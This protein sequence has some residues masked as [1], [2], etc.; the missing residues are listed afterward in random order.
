M[1][2]I[3]KVSGAGGSSGGGGSPTLTPDTLLSKDIVEFTL[4]LC[5][6]PIAGLING[7]RSFYLDQTPLV[8]GS[9]ENNF[10]PFELHMYH[11]EVDASPVRNILGGT[12]SNS[13]IGVSLAQDIPV[14]RTTTGT[15]REQ[16]DQL[17]IRINFNTLL[18]STAA[19]DQLEDVAE[20]EIKYR[21]AGTFAWLDFF[22]SEA[23][24]NL[25]LNSYV[26]P[27]PPTP[28]EGP[29]SVSGSISEADASIG[30]GGGEPVADSNG[31][32]VA[33]IIDGTPVE[34]DIPL[35]G[36][37]ETQE[38]FDTT[39]FYI[40]GAVADVSL[41]GYDFSKTGSYGTLFINSTN[42]NYRYVPNEAVITALT[43]AATETFQFRS[44]LGRYRGDLTVS[45]Q[46]PAVIAITG[47][48]SSGYTKDFVKGVP[49]ID[50]DWE[51][52]VVKRSPD[53]EEY[54]TI[55]MTWESL[56]MVTTEDRSYD[57]LAVVRGLGQASDQFSGIPTFAGVYGCKTI[58]V[59]SNYDPITRYCT[60]A[61]DGT[62]KIAHTDNPAW[63]FYD[64]LTNELYGLKRYYPHLVVDRYSI[65]DAAKWCDELVPRPGGGFQPRFTYNDKIAQS[66]NAL[67]LAYQIAAI[68]GA[69]PSS[70]MNGT[71]SLKL[72]KPGLPQQIFGPESVSVDGFQYSFSDVT[73]RPNDVLVK[74]IN[75]NLEFGEDVRQVYDQDLI[76]RNGRIPDEIVVLGCNDV[77]EAQRR[78]YRRIL[79]ANTETTSVSFQTARAGLGLEPFDLIGIADPTMNWGVSGRVK[80]RETDVI[81]LRDTLFL[82]VDTDLTFTLQ[83]ASGLH[84]MTVVTTDPATKVLRI[85]AGTWPADAPEFAQFAVTHAQIGLV[86]P[87]RVMRIEEDPENPEILTFTA[88]EQNVNKYSDA[89]NMASTGTVDYSAKQ[90]TR[91]LQPV[92]TRLESGTNHLYIN[93]D[94]KVSSR[95]F[96]QWV[97]PANSY[98]DDF[99]VFYRRK[100]VEQQFTKKAVSG[101]EA[102][103]ENVVDGEKYFIY[104][105]AV[106]SVGKRS[107][108][109]IRTSHTVVG[110]TQ[111]PANVESLTATQTGPDVRLT[112]PLLDELDISHYEFRLGDENSS[113][114]TAELIG[115]SSTGSFLDRN[116]KISPAK[117][118]VKAYDTSQNTSL[119]STSTT[120]AVPAPGKPTASFSFDKSQFV[121]NIASDPTDEVGVAEYIVT[122][123][124]NEVFR[125]NTSRFSGPA[126]W[127]GAREY[128]VTVKNHAGQVSAPRVITGTIV[129]PAAPE[130]TTFVAETAYYLNWST[131]ASTLPIDYYIVKNITTD[132]TLVSRSPGNIYTGNVG[133]LG[134]YNFSVQAVDTAGNRGALGTG[135]VNIVAP[136]VASLNSEVS[137]SV[138]KLTWVGEAL[139]LPIR[140]YL[141]SEGTSWEDSNQLGFVGG[142]SFSLPVD[143]NGSKTFYVAAID[144]AGNVGTPTSVVEAIDPPG[145]PE[146]SADI[147]DQNIHLTWTDPATELLIE[148]FK[149]E[150]RLKKVIPVFQADLGLAGAD[151]S[152]VVE[153]LDHLVISTGAVPTFDISGKTSGYSLDL[154]SEF[155]KQLY[156]N[157]VTVRIQASKG[158]S[159]PSDT[160]SATYSTAGSGDSGAP[161]PF[162]LTDTPQWF[163]FDYTIF[164]SS[165][166]VYP[167]HVVAFWGEAGKDFKL[168]EIQI[169]SK[170]KTFQTVSSTAASF[171]ARFLGTTC[172][173][174]TPY[175][176][177]GNVGTT[178]TTD[179]TIE[180]PGSFELNTS[181][182]D[183]LASFSWTSPE[184]TLPIRHYEL[185][186]GDSLAGSAVVAYV[187]ANTHSF[188]AD[189]E[190]I[191]TFWM[192]AVDTA[193][194]RSAAQ[195]NELEIVA[196]TAPIPRSEVIDNNVLLRWDNGTGTL[197][198]QTTEIRKGEIFA[199][200]E[201]LQKVDATFAAFFE[202]NAGDYT[203]WLV[204][205]DSA[206]NYGTPVAMATVVSEPPDFVL[207]TAFSSDFSGTLERVV[208]TLTGIAFGIN[209]QDTYNDHFANSGFDT[210]QQQVDGGYPYFLQPIDHLTPAY[211]QETTDLLGVLK[212]SIITVSPTINKLAGDGVIEIDIEVRET[213]TDPWT[214]H[215]NTKR[216]YAQNFRYLRITLRLVADSKHDLIE[217]T[218]L[219]V[220]LNVKIRND[221]G[222]GVAAAADAGGTPVQ[223]NVSF[224]DVASIT[225]TPNTTTPVIPVYD[226]V[227]TQNPTSFLVY[228]FD[229]DGNRV[230][231]DFS[232][233]VRGY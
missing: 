197:P 113:W 87:F 140:R 166:T 67:E 124:N 182:V 40:F 178:G 39:D 90:P 229:K 141:V 88:L 154:E 162:T 123:N 137:Q 174:V 70:D 206:G 109:K 221:A 82:P 110:K 84:E 28:G 228:L 15:L 29:G 168:F 94:G 170:I 2:N 202:F 104:V 157:T 31:G 93:Q 81:S 17:E 77:Y 139:S 107:D 172:Y 58:R 9:D 48:T 64:L 4:G 91:P 194:N 59:P 32:I 136:T 60:G 126:D 7:P 213:D 16:I 114:E 115:Q 211:Y 19:G 128:S 176:V 122:R 101:R 209:D 34:K 146:V 99:L 155:S 216:V 20:F 41:S 135:F 144:T 143:W 204:D 51:I 198:I 231:G 75:P 95:I 100:D 218:R 199:S 106:N 117:Y 148:T 55:N 18:K 224:V 66:R 169:L 108:H 25:H 86:K 23:I 97:Q 74:F 79:Q 151:I 8:S 181:V 111:P 1:S 192:V 45:V 72:D 76:D 159:T 63:C 35:G 96:L 119:V 165:S 149:L 214:L 232:W 138:L 78:G 200:A 133:W 160:F 163:E 36:N 215:S 210:I 65:Y 52:Q 83:T 121:I 102:Y 225:V 46:N 147:L 177:A 158:G 116:I 134:N 42:A 62:F 179:L 24:A 220:R 105:V 54:R 153:G 118:F 44:S 27:L 11:G 112:Y 43:T 185:S 33:D 193:G 190:G 98:V 56:Q 150:S 219:D 186:R 188:P 120:H 12:T 26:E 208:P 184:A 207:Q 201:V 191:E 13:Q 50:N 37:L 5:E 125:G 38:V 92:I 145:Q 131:P 187:S 180:K 127:S 21:E 57:N 68:F 167:D 71:V 175:D 14:I 49:R 223:F 80:S 230:D 30:F 205:I 183:N 73:Q 152:S 10:N 222:S 89:D 47:K 217:V 142:E 85:T 227:D 164:S 233:A 22:G 196:P 156:A 189:W 171:P 69:V 173:F 203:Y 132:Q 226:F 103:I 6:G 212:S 53:N 3:R 129:A 130:L 161:T 195:S 61:W